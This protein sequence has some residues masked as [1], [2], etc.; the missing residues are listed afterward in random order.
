MGGVWGSLLDEFRP[1]LGRYPDPDNPYWL[2]AV[3]DRDVVEGA[4]RQDDWNEITV[5]AVGPRIEIRLNGV[6]TVEFFEREDLVQGGV[7]CLQVHNGGPS[8]AWYRDIEIRE[9][10]GKR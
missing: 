7:I 6:P 3:A 8:R 2:L 9:L 10:N 5:T 4:L 1:D